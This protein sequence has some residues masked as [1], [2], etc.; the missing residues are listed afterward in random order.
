MPYQM[1]L[2]TEDLLNCR[3]VV[4]P[5]W[6]TQQAVRLLVHPGGAGVHLPWLRQSGEAAR[7]LGLEALW[8]LMPGRG[9]T[10]DFLCP[11]PTGPVTSFDE[12]M[13][14]VRRTDPGLARAELA[15][16]L[17]DTPG[18][19]DTPAGRAMLDDPAAAVRR[20]ADAKTRAWE[21]L[22]A[23]HWPRLRALLEA[24]IAFHTRRLAD[25][26]LAAL[27]DGLHS[28]VSWT[29]G[30]LTVGHCRAYTRT[31]DGE[32]LTLIPSLF[33]WPHV[34]SGF[35]PPWQPAV[36]YPAR[37]IGALWSDAGADA[38]AGLVRLL[39]AN[40]AAVLA[41]LDSPAST[42]GLAARLGLAPSSVSV[43]L[44]AL[45]GAGLLTSYRLR[46]QVLYERTPLGIA[47]AAGEYPA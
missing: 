31:L 23:P 5:S 26:G 46:H 47:L 8:L 7:G 17:A 42:T 28:E 25:G 6:E 19:A 4:S 10:P 14:R 18:A 24:D 16:S 12:E 43:H 21:V 38:P 30:T 33:A 27:F 1:H 15:R 37:G 36:V 13:A 34:I 2:G 45:R 40:R 32:G 3:F 20:L 11:P 22:I 29:D 39:G 35:E 41:A 44:S 9:Y